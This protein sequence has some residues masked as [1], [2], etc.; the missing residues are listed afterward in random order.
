MSKTEIK[1]EAIEEKRNRFNI[2][3]TFLW[4]LNTINT[5]LKGRNIYKKHDKGLS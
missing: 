5:S 4:V 3:V 1:A 2:K